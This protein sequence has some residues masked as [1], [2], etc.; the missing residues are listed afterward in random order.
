MDVV[1]QFANA[2]WPVWIA[3]AV[4]GVIGL[5]LL[6]T[7][8]G[9]MMGGKVVTG[10]TRSFLGLALAA[11]GAAVGLAALNLHTYQRL[12][13]ERP[14]AVI[15]LKQSGPQVYVAT[16]RVPEQD[17]K[18]YDVLGD[19]WRMEARVLKWKPWAN[20]IGFDAHFRLE[21]LSGRYDSVEQ[22]RDGA[23]SVHQ[24]ADNPGVDLWDL[25]RRYSKTVPVADAM[26]G[27]GVFAPMADGASYDV[28]MTQTGLIARPANAEA[29]A[30]LQNWR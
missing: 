18:V 3:P 17:A 27:S 19:A 23:R 2:D 14:V 13:Y 10:V 22:E 28:M 11:G 25:A 7:G 1:T 21:R 4:L 15:S 8:L 30:A 26:Y 12:S 29:E 5:I 16:V 24:M 20:I 9:R 6:L